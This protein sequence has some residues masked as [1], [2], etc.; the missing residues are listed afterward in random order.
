M[1]DERAMRMRCN[2]LSIPSVVAITKNLWSWETSI[3]CFEP[4][5]TN[6]Q[7]QLYNS[8]S[9]IFDF[10]FSAMGSAL[11]SSTE[12]PQMF[13]LVGLLVGVLGAVAL[14]LITALIVVITRRRPAVNA[15]TLL[16]Q[17]E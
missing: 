12:R 16:V 3:P 5:N 8:S 13:L 10:S 11:K 14:G 2:R 15:A 9:E 4:M 17:D 1:C 6:H 7:W